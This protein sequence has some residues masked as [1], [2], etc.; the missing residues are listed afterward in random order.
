MTVMHKSRG[1]GSHLHDPRNKVLLRLLPALRNLASVPY[2]A[3][4]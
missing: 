4:K 1:L 2:D 3:H